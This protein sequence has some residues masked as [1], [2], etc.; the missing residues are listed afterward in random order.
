MRV[1]SC[2]ICVLGIIY[3][4]SSLVN[5][6]YDGEKLN[7]S[8]GE[9]LF[10]NDAIEFLSTTECGEFIN[11]DYKTNNV[12]E[13]AKRYLNNYDYKI[14]LDILKSEYHEIGKGGVIKNISSGIAKKKNEGLSTEKMCTDLLRK[15]WKS[16][17][18]TLDNWNIDKQ[19]Y[20]K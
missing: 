19:L 16:Y 12:H 4:N 6:E 1:T 10:M 17:K 11:F 20:S 2:L 8:L 5:A 13:E 14:F 7:A 18:D 15:V 9:L 3:I